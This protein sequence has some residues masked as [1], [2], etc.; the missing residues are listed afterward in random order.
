MKP[1]KIAAWSVDMTNLTQNTVR[2]AKDLGA[3]ILP[4]QTRANR[5]FPSLDL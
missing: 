3:A 2:L 1:K 4:R 5:H